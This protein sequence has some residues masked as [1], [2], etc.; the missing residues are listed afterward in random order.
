METQIMEMNFS[1]QSVSI[2]LSS[3]KSIRFYCR[4]CE[5]AEMDECVQKCRQY[6]SVVR[7]SKWRNENRPENKGLKGD[8]NY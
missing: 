6:V 3:G 1:V 8:W 7:Y 5:S 4:P 2:D